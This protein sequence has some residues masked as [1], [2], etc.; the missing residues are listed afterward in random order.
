MDLVR[1]L[2]YSITREVRRQE[3][4]N[5]IMP[6]WR[7]DIGGESTV[8][9]K[10]LPLGPLTTR[11]RPRLMTKHRLKDMKTTQASLEGNYAVTYNLFYV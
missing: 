10:V 6:G 5:V 4:G 1:N 11:A 8:D 3:G 2:L 7:W 9:P